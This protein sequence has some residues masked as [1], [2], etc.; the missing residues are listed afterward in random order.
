MYTDYMTD[1]PDNIVLEHLRRMRATLDDLRED[2]KDLKFRLGVVER[3][4]ISVQDIL[5]QHSMQFDRLG[6][7]L[8]RIEKRLTLVE[9]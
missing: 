6:T 4:L 7:R 9:I 5:V 3:G 2:N 1:K 8:E